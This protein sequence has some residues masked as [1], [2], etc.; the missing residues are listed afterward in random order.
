L[1]VEPSLASRTD[2]S[3]ELCTERFVEA[4]GRLG[5][6]GLVFLPVQVA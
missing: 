3:I 2:Y 6:D 4:C 1:G 5:L